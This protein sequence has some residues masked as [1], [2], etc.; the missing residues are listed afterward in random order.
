M[1]LSKIKL[2]DSF[3]IS[4]PFMLVIYWKVFH[5]FFLLRCYLLALEDSQVSLPHFTV[6]KMQGDE[7][8]IAEG[9]G[10]SHMG[11]LNPT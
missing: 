6:Q 9:V 4:F 3:K 10:M 2:I 11:D 1:Y 8:S 7:L 5:S